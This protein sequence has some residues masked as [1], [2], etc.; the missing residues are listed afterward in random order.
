M[1][2]LFG[3]EKGLVFCGIVTVRTRKVPAAPQT[4]FHTST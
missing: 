1:G 4:S 3:E 2:S